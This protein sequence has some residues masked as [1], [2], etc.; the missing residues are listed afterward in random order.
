[1]SEKRLINKE[2]EQ[3]YNEVSEEDRLSTGLGA[4]EFTRN[5]ELIEKFLPSVKA[6]VIDVGGGTG[7][8]AE[9]MAKKEHDVF[10]VDP[11]SKHIKEAQ[12]RAE[13][14]K[15]GFKVLLGEAQNL[16][17]QDNFADL[18][19]LHGPL[20]HLQEKSER[21]KAIMEAKRVLKPDGIVLGFAINYTASLLVGLLQ[22]Y[23]H[24]DHFFKMCK[25]ELSSGI[26]QPPE[27]LPGLFTHAYYHN[28][29]ELKEEI[30]AAGLEYVNTFA[31][32]GVAW[33]DK[34]YFVN[35]SDDKKKERLFGLI[36]M[37]ETD[38]NLLSISPHM[39]IAAK[40]TS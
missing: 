10:L 1:M 4:L 5:K 14:L 26:H 13:S 27:S 16:D 15:N 23:I 34:D 3:F 40:K 6:I 11:V 22:G 2:I 36:R 20:Y 29:E 38:P 31:I 7:K 19:I 17:F 37:T 12:K 21:K 39:M 28:P 35:M 8:Y 33:L 9:W 24:D 25:Q 32:E 18:V 30:L